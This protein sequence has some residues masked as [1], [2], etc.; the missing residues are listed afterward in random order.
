MTLRFWD[1]NVALYTTSDTFAVVVNA[2]YKN[3]SNLFFSQN[4]PRLFVVAQSGKT[5][6]PQ[7]TVRRPFCKL[8]LCD[9]L[10]FDWEVIGKKTLCRLLII[11]SFVFWW[12]KPQE[13]EPV[14]KLGPP[15]EIVVPAQEEEPK[16][17]PDIIK[18]LPTGQSTT[19]AAA[20]M[21]KFRF[22]P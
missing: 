7:V 19:A 12:P 21:P 3:L 15:N 10:R 6:V 11:F 8:D 16:G 4:S 20:I 9:Q 17:P 13:T 14:G 18:R 5:R 2:A 1:E 22:A